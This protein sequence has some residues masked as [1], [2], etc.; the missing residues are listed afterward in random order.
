MFDTPDLLLLLVKSYCHIAALLQLHRQTI[1]MHA[2]ISNVTTT[3]KQNFFFTVP[4]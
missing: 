3:E 4:T 2:F 1:C